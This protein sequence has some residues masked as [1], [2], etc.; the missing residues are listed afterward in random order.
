MSGVIFQQKWSEELVRLLL[1][2]LIYIIFFFI[3]DFILFNQMVI[4][5]FEEII[6]DL[7]RYLGMYYFLFVITPTWF[8]EVHFTMSKR[9]LWESQGI[10]F[11]YY[12][13][14]YFN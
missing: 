3:Y 1:V 13:I 14:I 12:L 10:S 6:G 9:V 4:E 11:Y 5:Y 2:Y 8:L 7:K